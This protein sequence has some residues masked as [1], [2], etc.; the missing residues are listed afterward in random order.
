LKPTVL[1]QQLNILL[2]GFQNSKRCTPFIL[3]DIPVDEKI[4]SYYF[5]MKT[6]ATPLYCLLSLTEKCLQQFRKE[7][8]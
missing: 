5:Y 6:L 4:I 7:F 2:F 8:H 3:E 1:D